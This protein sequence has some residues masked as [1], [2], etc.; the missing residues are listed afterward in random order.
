RAADLADG[1]RP[2]RLV[3][4]RRLAG[5]AYRLDGVLDPDNP[6]GDPRPAAAA[7]AVARDRTGGG[8][9]NPSFGPEGGVGR[10]ASNSSAGEPARSGAGRGYSRHGT[11]S[12]RVP[13]CG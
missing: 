8:K 4:R 6:A 5:G 1:V 12:V 10:S 2:H 9:R 7:L 13:V 3:G 11:S